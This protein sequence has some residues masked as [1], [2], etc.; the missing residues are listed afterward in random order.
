MVRTSEDLALSKEAKALKNVLIAANITLNIH[1]QNF[2]SFWPPIDLD[3][4]TLLLR[5]YANKQ[6][7]KS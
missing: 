5:L 6:L 3:D 4:A 2:K 1:A 7:F